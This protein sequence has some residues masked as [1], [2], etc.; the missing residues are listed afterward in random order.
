MCF[1][2][3]SAVASAITVEVMTRLMIVGNFDRLGVVAQAVFR[4]NVEFAAIFRYKQ[5]VVAIPAV[6]VVVAQAGNLLGRAGILIANE[7][8]IFTIALFLPKSLSS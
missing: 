2:L 3:E 6:G 4:D 1:W 5:I 8:G 7:Q